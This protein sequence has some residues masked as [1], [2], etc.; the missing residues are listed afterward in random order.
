MF[1]GVSTNGTSPIL[2][3]IGTSSGV[4]ATSYLGSAWTA[5][6]TNTSNSTGFLISADMAATNIWHGSL[7]LSLVNSNIWVIQG[8]VGRSDAATCAVSGG[9]KSLSGTLDRLRITTVNGTDTFDA[10]SVNILYE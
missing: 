7:I 9:S 8:V 5:N 4:E 2:V 6:T 3:R 1:S 10:G